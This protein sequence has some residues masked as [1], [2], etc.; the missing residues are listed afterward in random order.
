MFRRRHETLERLHELLLPK[1]ERQAARA[2]RRVEQQLRLE[3]E[4][5]FSPERR[6]ARLEAECRRTN[7]LGR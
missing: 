6:A 7:F 4:N 1:S 5:R 2:E 3:R